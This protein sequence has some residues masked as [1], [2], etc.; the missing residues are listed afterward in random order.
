MFIDE[1][2]DAT[3]LYYQWGPMKKLQWVITHRDKDGGGTE[4]QATN[5]YYDGMGRHT[6]T[7]FPDGSSEL[8]DWGVLNQVQAYKTRKNQT[9]RISYDARGREVSN[10]WDG[11]TAPGINRS[12]DNA[13]CL[14]SLSNVWS[15]INYSYDQAGQVRSESQNVAGA[16]G[17]AT[18]I[19]NR[20]PNGEVAH[21]TYPN[22]WM[23]VR[24]DYTSRGQAAAVGWDDSSG[25]WGLADVE[26]HLPGGWEDRPSGLLPRAG[27][28]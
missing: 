3:N 9:K 1:R 23:R 20:Y 6:W 27:D 21:L 2:N 18:L 25:N 10:T 26:L 8:S 4:D 7:I 28:L 19:Y 14:S 17:A 13:N 15:T 22:G 12:W 24:K 11:N 5:F 16:G